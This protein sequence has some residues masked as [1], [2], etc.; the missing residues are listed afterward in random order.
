MGALAR[1]KYDM[2]RNTFILNQTHPILDRYMRDDRQWLRGD[3]EAKR[4]SGLQRLPDDRAR[5][6]WE[7]AMRAVN[8][9]SLK[10]VRSH[11]QENRHLARLLREA[12][13]PHRTAKCWARGPGTAEWLFPASDSFVFR[14]FGLIPDAGSDH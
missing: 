9:A 14:I 1:K 6:A 12:G 4:T 5:D 3:L 2:R 7:S 13:W 8:A 11:K 10:E